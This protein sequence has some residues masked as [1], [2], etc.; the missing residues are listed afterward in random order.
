MRDVP[1][2]RGRLPLGGVWKCTEP[3]VRGPADIAVMGVFPAHIRG[4]MKRWTDAN[5]KGHNLATE[6]EETSFEPG[7]QSGSDIDQLYLRH[8][9]DVE[10]E[11]GRRVSWTRD[12]TCFFDMYPYYLASKDMKKNM[13][14]YERET[15]DTVDVPEKPSSQGVVDLATTLAG[16]DDRIAEILEA[17]SP[18]L[19]I[20]LGL[21]C[22]AFTREISHSEAGDEQ[23]ELLYADPESLM[24]CGYEVPVVHLAHPQAVRLTHWGDKNVKW[25]KGEGR[26]IV[27]SALCR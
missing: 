14:L 24:I 21:E 18:R 25:C 16:N 20:T 4:K 3:S 7:S 13:N 15:G 12:R 6:C 23:D 5:G 22:V 11:N 19:L 10:C 27:T 1:K 26:G 9:K 2:V 17:A 8:F